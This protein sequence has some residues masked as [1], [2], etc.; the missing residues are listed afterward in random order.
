[1]GSAWAK[2]SVLLYPL[3]R[4]CSWKWFWLY[5]FISF[6]LIAF[7]HFY[8]LMRCLTFAWLLSYLRTQVSDHLRHIS[9]KLTALNKQTEAGSGKRA[10]FMPNSPRSWMY[11]TCIRG[12]LSAWV[13]CCYASWSFAHYSLSNMRFPFGMYCMTR[14]IIRFWVD[15]HLRCKVF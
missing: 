2:C 3:A 7:V 12:K 14:T 4:T 15:E 11:C 6:S 1:M 9:V 8:P 10:S 5:Y 13:L